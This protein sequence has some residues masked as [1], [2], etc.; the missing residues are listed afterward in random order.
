[1]I[2]MVTGILFGVTTGWYVFP[3]MEETMRESRAFIR[4]KIRTIELTRK[5][6]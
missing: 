5:A 6:E 2:R 3:L 4:Q 1:M